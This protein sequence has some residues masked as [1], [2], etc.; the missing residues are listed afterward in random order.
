M[1]AK[2]KSPVLER[3]E[4]EESD[5]GGGPF[6][7]VY[8]VMF[9]DKY[10]GGRVALLQETRPTNLRT[11]VVEAHTREWASRW[12]GDDA[13]DR[14]ICWSGKDRCQGQMCCARDLADLQDIA[15]KRH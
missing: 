1:Y 15:G 3:L 9:S 6:L 2:R 10:R 12:R 7:T 5:G 8:L 4:R 13:E 11:R 14:E